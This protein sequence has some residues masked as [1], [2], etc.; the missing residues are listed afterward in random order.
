MLS[1][2]KQVLPAGSRMGSNACFISLLP[3]VCQILPKGVVG[4]LGPSSSPASSSIISNICGEKEVSGQIPYWGPAE[5]LPPRPV[6]H[7]PAAGAPWGCSIWLGGYE[8][9]IGFLE[10]PLP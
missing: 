7:P 5:I 6:L 1:K 10:F 3:T 2:V 9:C 8:A 4:V